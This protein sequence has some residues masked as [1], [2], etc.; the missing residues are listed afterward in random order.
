VSEVDV[1][2]V[3][4]PTQPLPPQAQLMIEG[5]IL[6]GKAT[7]FLIRGMHFS[8]PNSQPGMPPQPGQPYLG[9][10]ANTG[11][12]PMLAHYG[13]A[14]RQGLILDQR[15]ATAG[16]VIVG[17]EGLV[18]KEL[19]PLAQVLANGE[20][21]PLAGL[22]MIPMPFA[23]NISLVDDFEAVTG[24]VVEALELARTSEAS[25]ERTNAVVITR[26]A[27][28]S[29]KPGEPSGPFSV[30]YAL[31]GRFTSAFSGPD[32]PP[33]ESSA[34][35]RIVV[36]GSADFASDE[37][38]GLARR[39]QMFRNLVAGATVLQNLVDWL[40]A[41]QALVAARTKGA[42]PPIDPPDAST[43]RWIKYG[44]IVGSAAT[45]LLIGLG[46]WFVRD[47]RRRSFQL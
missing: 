19:F 36:L 16:A 24:G 8:V 34:N 46:V 29:P 39:H 20:T 2:I 14:V 12:E 32:A 4:G 30:G 44:N 25:Y 10:P 1:L 7:L 38:L 6:A 41:D 18:V 5:H 28:L 3:N 40:A 35:T 31:S 45:L 27:D 43:K 17:T 9:M 21:D 37:T 23:S 13:V 22:S 15:A 26:D 42:P 33:Q 47:R 11:L